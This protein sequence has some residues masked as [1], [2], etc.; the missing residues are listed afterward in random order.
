MPYS[1]CMKTGR[2]ATYGGPPLLEKKKQRVFLVLQQ[3]SSRAL[4]LRAQSS[5]GPG[6]VQVPCVTCLHRHW[7]GL[8]VPLLNQCGKYTPVWGGHHRGDGGVGAG[9]LVCRPVRGGT[10]LAVVGQIHTPVPG[11]VSLF[12]GANLNS[13]YW[14]GC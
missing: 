4:I 8:P 1:I 11:P 10:S 5:V 14:G 9:G 7:P 3:M 2:G 13:F 12:A 6:L